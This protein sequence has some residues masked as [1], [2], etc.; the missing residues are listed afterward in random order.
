MTGCLERVRAVVCLAVA[1]SAAVPVLAA[2]P[3]ATEDADVLD[4]G[5]CELEATVSWLTAGAGQ[6]RSGDAKLSCGVGLRSQLDLTLGRAVGDAPWANY[7]VLG[8]KTHLAEPVP[9]TALALAYEFG[10]LSPSGQRTALEEV[11]L[12]G[13][14][15][16]E[17]GDGWT[18]H[19]NLG[20]LWLRERDD[21]RAT[22]GLALQHAF[23][24]RLA[25]MI[26]TYRRLAKDPWV[27]AGLRW[28][29]VEHVAL[30]ASI[31]HQTSGERA[32]LG[33]LGLAVSF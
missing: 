23:D 20:W 18:A 12:T 5:T 4:R 10:W 17:I 13:V 25:A 16:H 28:N 21:D 24:D 6:E 9:G 15:S 14:A 30:G 8:G 2:A 31:A 7:A 26:E 22:W 1:L 29:V 19:A 11:L 33:T 27:A 3:L 32:T